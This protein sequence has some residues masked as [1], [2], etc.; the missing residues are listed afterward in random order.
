MAESKTIIIYLLLLLF[1]N[2]FTGQFL[3]SQ[4]EEKQFEL[5]QYQ[6]ISKARG[7]LADEQNFLSSV[8]S[9]VLVPFLV[10][11]LIFTI[12]FTVSATLGGLPVIINIFIYS[13]LLIIGIVDY[14]APMIRGN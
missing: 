8:I 4:N 3:I 11:E 2:F 6:I 1:F 5:E 10:F 12:F 13:P 9:I 14:V 7:I